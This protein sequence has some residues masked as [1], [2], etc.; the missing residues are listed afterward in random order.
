MSSDNT[1]KM[2]KDVTILY[3]KSI[4]YEFY[5]EYYDSNRDFKVN[6]HYG[7]QDIRSIEFANNDHI[8]KK[9]IHRRGKVIT[10]YKNILS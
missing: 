7:I 2:Q 9:T 8:K 1:F 6:T 5:P 3:F 10:N 4:E